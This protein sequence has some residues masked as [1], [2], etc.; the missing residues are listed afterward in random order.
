MDIAA[1]VLKVAKP[2]H[3]PKKAAAPKGSA[4]ARRWSRQGTHLIVNTPPTAG[5]EGPLKVAA[6]DLDGTLVHTKSGL[7]FARG[8]SDW[9]W[10]NPTVPQT[11]AALARRGYVVAVFTNQGGVVATPSSKLY[12]NFTERVNQIQQALQM[13][14]L[15]WAAPKRPARAASPEDAHRRMRKPQTGMWLALCDYAAA[16]GHLVDLHHSF[17]VGDAAGRPADFL[18]SDRQFALGVGIEFKVPEDVFTKPTAS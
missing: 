15:V 5:L 18:D 13:D 6:F 7:K 1:L 12:S 8:A 16:S 11:L 3:K 4:F 2:P 10:F 9:R 17:F 14:L